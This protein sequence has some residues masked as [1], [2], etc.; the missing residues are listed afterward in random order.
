MKPA[1]FSDEL[2]S[3]EIQSGNKKRPAG[4][5]NLN[6]AP[7]PMVP[8]GRGQRFRG[9]RHHHGSRPPY[10]SPGSSSSSSRASAV[11]NGSQGQRNPSPFQ[12]LTANRR[13][14]SSEFQ[15][16]M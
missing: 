14:M 10:Q 1:S 11:S 2:I 9:G 6:G 13:N 7:T 16:N 5:P 3:R 8:R 12:Y 4:L 15:R